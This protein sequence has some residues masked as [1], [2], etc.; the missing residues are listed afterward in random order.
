MKTLILLVALL[1]FSL[2]RGYIT[3]NTER[4]SEYVNEAI[5]S[6]WIRKR[7]NNYYK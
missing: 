4:F 5:N 1:C 3:I 7:G 6:S 2:G